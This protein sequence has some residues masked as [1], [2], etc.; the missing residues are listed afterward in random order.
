MDRFGADVNAETLAAAVLRDGFA[1]VDDVLPDAATDR[2]AAGLRAML[3][4]QPPG[5]NS[6]VGYKTKRIF[7]VLAKSRIVDELVIHPLV[8]GVLD[9]VL[10]KY[11]LSAPVVIEIE[12]GER[13]QTLH[14]DSTTYPL[15]Q[16]EH[17]VVVNV[18]WA[19]DDFTALN[20]AT[21]LIPGSHRWVDESA[22][23]EASTVQAIMGKGSMCVFL[24]SIVHGG[25]ANA[26]EAPRLGVTMEYAA[27]WLRPQENF[28]LS[29]PR[30]TARQLP[31]RLAELIGYDLYPPFLGY[32]DGRNPRELLT[33]PVTA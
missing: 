18:M 14:R 8:L 12:P 17:T 26:S 13:A 9:T 30:D 23:D 20:G 29:V 31:L 6:F 33:G 32:V 11:Q 16:H 22:A 25:G 3:L 28:A 24:G 1:I 7:S 15:A 4:D 10:D 27:A 19:F 5:A 21:R 2:I